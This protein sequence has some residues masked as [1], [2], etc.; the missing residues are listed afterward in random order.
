MVE[1]LSEGGNAFFPHTGYYPD[2]EAKPQ[3]VF[4]EARRH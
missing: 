3:I 1:K 2:R 4:N